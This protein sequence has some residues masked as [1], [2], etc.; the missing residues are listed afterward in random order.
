MEN[1]FLNWW[2]R[3]VLREERPQFVEV[4]EPLE[5]FDG[6]RVFCRLFNGLLGCVSDVPELG[7]GEFFEF[8]FGGHWTCLL[9][10]G[11][12]DEGKPKS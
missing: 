6:L 5:V 1:E 10:V 11:G 8:R 7:P 9:M 2:W 4:S 3:E 12:R